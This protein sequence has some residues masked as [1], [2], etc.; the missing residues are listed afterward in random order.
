[1]TLLDRYLIK[2]FL[3]IMLLVLMS[4]VAIYLLVDF[5]ERIDD[6]IDADKS[7]GLAVFYFLLKIPFIIDQLFPVCTLLAGTITIGLL[8]R[9]KELMSLHAGGIN[10]IRIF[11]P[12]FFAACTISLIS[13]GNAQWIFPKAITDSERIW[14]E[15]VKN[16]DV[17]G[18]VRHGWVFYKGKEGFYSFKHTNR[19]GWQFENFKYTVLNT[20]N[21]LQLYL[22]AEKAT[23]EKN[24]WVFI[25]GQLKT[26]QGD[27]SY[28][29]EV[30]PEMVKTLPDI[31]SDFFMPPYQ[32]DRLSI[33]QLIRQWLKGGQDTDRTMIELHRRLSFIFLG[34]P[35]LIIAIPAMLLIH[36]RLRA[37]LAITIPA[38]CTLAFGA[39]ALW[40][41][42]QALSQAG[43]INPIMASWSIHVLLTVSGFFLLWRLNRI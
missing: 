1:M 6:F 33:S 43:H 25:N 42:G 13:L 10:I 31:P 17:K 34:I 5:F 12:I 20:D 35:L 36:S 21:Q 14:Q 38:S 8:Y 11:L 27:G 30:F 19:N 26:L 9:N 37:D 39:W 2:K 29:I 41:G 23:W 7:I 28:N 22:I 4:L 15:E 24:S 40:N 32:S 3:G 18:I 16:R